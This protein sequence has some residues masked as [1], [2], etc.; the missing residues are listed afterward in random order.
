M[1][2]NVQLT[3]HCNVRSLLSG[4]FFYLLKGLGGTGR[5]SL[6]VSSQCYSCENFAEQQVGKIKTNQVLI[7]FI[8]S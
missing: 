3:L 8:Q 2:I 5:T 1:I 4:C 6:C 7:Q